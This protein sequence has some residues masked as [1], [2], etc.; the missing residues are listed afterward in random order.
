[1]PRYDSVKPTA[2]ASTPYLQVVSAP[3]AMAGEGAPRSTTFG[4]IGRT[5]Y[6]YKNRS[7]GGLVVDTKTSGPLPAG[8]SMKATAAPQTERHILGH[9]SRTPMPGAHYGM[10]PYAG[11]FMSHEGARL[12]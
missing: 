7:L 12:S 10:K 5:T 2:H 6:D 1:M 11:Q 9:A 8:T 4:V 3:R